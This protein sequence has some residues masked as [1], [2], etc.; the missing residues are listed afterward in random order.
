MQKQNKCFVCVIFLFF[1]FVL[2]RFRIQIHL[3]LVELLQ[4]F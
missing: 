1:D 2:I 4:V 3:V